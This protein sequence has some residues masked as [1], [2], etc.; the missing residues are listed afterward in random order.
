MLV[1]HCPFCGPRNESEFAYGG[2]AQA[3]RP[4]PGATTDADWVTWLTVPENRIGPVPER[5]CHL[6]GCG[7]WLTLMRH[8]VTHA[9][10]EV[11][12]GR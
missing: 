9:I 3:P 1:I 11:R 2:P 5:W 12:H 7:S 10:T 8:T 6:R 4:D